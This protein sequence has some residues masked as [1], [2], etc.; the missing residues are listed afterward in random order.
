MEEEFEDT[1]GVIR[2]RISRNRQRNCQKKKTHNPTQKVKKMSN[3]DPTTN[4]GE[5]RFS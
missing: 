1:K 2:S 3:T 4:W 5:A